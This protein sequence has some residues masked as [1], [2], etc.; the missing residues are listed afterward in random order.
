MRVQVMQPQRRRL[1]DQQAEDAAAVRQVTNRA[2]RLRV[3]P[4]RDEAGE[5]LARFVEHAERR[6]A[7]AGQL[8]RRVEHLGEQRLEI[9]LGDERAPD[10]NEP[11]QPLLVKVLAGDRCI[12]SLGPGAVPATINRWGR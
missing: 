9:T 1:L 7:G 6:I 10:L 8:A 2:V 11:A 4:A 12:P 3:D 5:R